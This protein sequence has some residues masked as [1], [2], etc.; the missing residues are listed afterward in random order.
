M[1]N[2]QRMRRVPSPLSA[3]TKKHLLVSR[4]CPVC[5]SPFPMSPSEGR[6]ARYIDQCSWKGIVRL[7]VRKVKHP[8]RGGKA[9]ESQRSCIFSFLLFPLALRPVLFAPCLPLSSFQ[10]RVSHPPF[11]LR[12]F[13]FSFLLFT[14]AFIP[15]SAVQCPTCTKPHHC[16]RVSRSPYR[17]N[18]PWKQAKQ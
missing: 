4:K 1:K 14:F 18:H 8:R 9:H 11:A 12:R 13:I 6:C 10:F 3:K 16:S 15:P 2:E 7:R 17:R 5:S